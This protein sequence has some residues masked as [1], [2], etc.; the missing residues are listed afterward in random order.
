MVLLGLALIACAAPPA[1]VVPA[2]GTVTL[3]PGE[4]AQLVGSDF[5]VTFEKVVRDD[6]CPVGVFCIHFGDARVAFRA[7]GAGVDTTVVLST[8]DTAASAMI[9]AYRIELEALAPFKQQEADIPAAA[10]RAT[11]KVSRSDP[12]PAGRP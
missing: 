8:A 2:D 9:G 1:T 5:V 6:R 10:Y 3:A 7:A 4:R 12:L 11:V